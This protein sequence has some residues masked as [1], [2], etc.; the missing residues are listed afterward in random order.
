VC[1]SATRIVQSEP[2]LATSESE[3]NSCVYGTYSAHRTGGANRWVDPHAGARKILEWS[4]GIVMT[5]AAM[6]GAAASAGVVFRDGAAS[7]DRSTDRQ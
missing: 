4:G 5:G 2:A 1:V 3:L 7:A 6:S